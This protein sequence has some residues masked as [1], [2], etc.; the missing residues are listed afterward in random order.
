MINPA[1][2]RQW[3]FYTPSEVAAA[4][5]ILRAKR[6]R[7][8]N[9]PKGDGR[10]TARSTGELCQPF[11]EVWDKWAA[12]VMT[13]YGRFCQLLRRY[14]RIMGGAALAQVAIWK[15]LKSGYSVPRMLRDEQ[16]KINRAHKGLK[17]WIQNPPQDRDDRAR[18]GS[19]I[20]PANPKTNK[21]THRQQIINTTAR[22]QTAA[23]V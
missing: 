20:T 9:A 7:T 15:N 2:N 18:H 10:T 21:H 8:A 22:L 23:N 11:E 12:K 1:D 16:D 13:W 5:D 19:A 6:G 3:Y 4:R 17:K 14:A